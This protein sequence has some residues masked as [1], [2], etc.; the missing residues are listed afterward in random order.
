MLMVLLSL[1]LYV[2]CGEENISVTVMTP[3]IQCG[4]CQKTIEMGLGKRGRGSEGRTL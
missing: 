3:T 4:M 1:S 2:G